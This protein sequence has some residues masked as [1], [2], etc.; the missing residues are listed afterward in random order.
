MSDWRDFRVP[1]R[2]QRGGD[3]LLM[4]HSM[5]LAGGLAEEP[6]TLNIPSGDWAWEWYDLGISRVEGTVRITVQVRR[7][8]VTTVINVGECAGGTIFNGVRGACPL[9]L[10]GGDSVTF[11][12]TYGAAGMLAQAELFLRRIL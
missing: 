9:T 4:E 3:S 1:V 7:G 11:V 10:E 8:N 5:L 6:L 2:D 12:M